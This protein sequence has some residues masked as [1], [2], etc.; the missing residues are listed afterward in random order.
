MIF[1]LFSTHFNMATKEEANK[2][3]RTAYKRAIYQTDILSGYTLKIQ[4]SGKRA[5]VFVF[6]N[7]QNVI[8]AHRGTQGWTDK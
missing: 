1:H 5:E 2:A 3:E 8:L 4:L 6:K 7:K